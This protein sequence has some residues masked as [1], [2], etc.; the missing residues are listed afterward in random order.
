MNIG[1][2]VRAVT[3]V[4]PFVRIALRRGA[5]QKAVAVAAGSVVAHVGVGAVV[6]NENI[7]QVLQVVVEIIGALALVV[8]AFKGHNVVI[9]RAPRSDS[10]L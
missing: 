6:T 7:V 5:V 4:V 9:D 8:A 3:R 2:I 10:I 1:S